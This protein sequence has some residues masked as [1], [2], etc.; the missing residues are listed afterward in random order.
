MEYR[1]AQLR[2]HLTDPEFVGL[3]LTLVL[4]ATVGAVGAVA[5]LNVTGATSED[6]LVWSVA[7]LTAV[8]GGRPGGWFFDSMSNPDKLGWGFKV[9]D[10][11]G[12]AATVHPG[13]KPEGLPATFAVTSGTAPGHSTAGSCSAPSTSVVVANASGW[14]DPVTFGLPSTQP[15]NVAA[16]APPLPSGLV[17]WLSAQSIS[18]VTPG[19][20]IGS[21]EN[22]ASGTSGTPPLS[23]QAFCSHLRGR[24]SR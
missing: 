2:W 16:A 4:T 6:E 5:E 15:L 21:W 17:L 1:A 18:G 12:N 24:Y 13:S 9:E 19:Q 11:T 14:A 7:G 22:L 23:Q 20:P 10:S 8:P 3:D